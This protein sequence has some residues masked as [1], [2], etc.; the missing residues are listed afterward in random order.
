MEIYLFFVF[1]RLHLFQLF[2]ANVAIDSAF[3]ALEHGRNTPLEMEF[4]TSKLQNIEPLPVDTIM[5]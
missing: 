2:Q 5:R 1:Y 4:R 3:L